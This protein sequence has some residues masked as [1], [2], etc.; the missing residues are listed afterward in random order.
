VVDGD[1]G[2]VLESLTIDN[3]C[4]VE[5]INEWEKLQD[6]HSVYDKVERLVCELTNKYAPVGCIG[7]TGQMHGI[8]Y[9]NK[10]GDA[11]SPLYTWQDGRGDIVLK[12]GISYCMDLIKKTGYS[13]ASG[14]GVVTHYYNLKNNIVPTTAWNICTIQDY[15]AMRLAQRT[16]P[17][18]NNSDA[19]S[20]GLF[21]IKSNSFDVTALEFA[22]VAVSLFPKININPE[23][24][25]MTKDGIPVAVAIGDNQ[26]SFI[27]SVNSVHD[28][29]LVNIGTGSQIS[30][31]TTSYVEW[32]HIDVRPFF[33]NGCLLVG[34]PL[35]GG[36]GYALLESF[37]REVAKMVTGCE[38]T[39][40]YDVM[41]KAVGDFMTLE[42]KL[43]ISTQ[44]CGTRE[45]PNAR[46]SIKNIGVHNFTPQHFTVGVLEGMVEKL[47]DFYKN[48][49]VNLDKKPTKLIG[50]G[51]GIRRNQILQKIISKQ[52]NLSLKIPVYTEEAAN[53]AT[54]FTLVGIGYF[55]NLTEAQSIIRY[56]E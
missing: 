14:Y 13:L 42:N 29:V 2:N 24:I 1:T 45:E 5:T 47:F 6:V 33:G 30:V 7:V 46:G 9:I 49:L 31:H 53:G 51:N 34:S 26:A 12:E 43:N 44:F 21:D 17:L 56:W 19:L 15:V 20:L 22:G 28:S 37:F 40:L 27:G 41:G 25:G 10:D 36:H 35:C 4:Y 11:V 38:F 3:G 54:L 48:I 23:I 8:L 16:V 52:F 18:I 55:K 50:S 32:P 39:E